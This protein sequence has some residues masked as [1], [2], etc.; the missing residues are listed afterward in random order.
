[1]LPSCLFWGRGCSEGR[2][3][4]EI[5]GQI[6]EL[7]HQPRGRASMQTESFPA[8]RKGCW[9]RE[10]LFLALSQHGW[11]WEETVK[12]LWGWGARPRGLAPGIG[13]WGVGRRW[14]PGG[15]CGP[16][17]L[18]WRGGV[19]AQGSPPPQGEGKGALEGAGEKGRGRTNT[20]LALLSATHG[21]G[22]FT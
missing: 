19:T 7:A 15:L 9:Q 20:C 2:G 17:G 14:G 11:K 3:R 13:K 8:G 16:A 21:S 18:A 4:R 6:S 22:C 10:T 1:M 5:W 12:A